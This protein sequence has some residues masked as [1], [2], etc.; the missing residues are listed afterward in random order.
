LANLYHDEYSKCTLMARMQACR[1][2]G[3]CSMSHLTNSSF[4]FIYEERQVL[5]EEDYATGVSKQALS[6]KY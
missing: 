2:L 5:E 3:H 4:T 6:R 1:R